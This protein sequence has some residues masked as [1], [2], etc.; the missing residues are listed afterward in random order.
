MPGD[1]AVELPLPILAAFD[2]G[3]SH[4]S[5]GESVQPLLA[6]HCE[7]SGEERSGETCVE[8]GLDL[9]DRAWG[10]RPLWNCRNAT[11]ESSTVHCVNNNAKKSGGLF[12]RV[13][14]EF[15]VDLDNERGGYGGE[16]TSL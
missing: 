6:E 14:L 16:Q 4:V 9:D 2:G 3:S 8:E 7:E 11:T 1:D 13:W 15:G 10:A 5:R 12:V